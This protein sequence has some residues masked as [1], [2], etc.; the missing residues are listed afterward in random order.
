MAEDAPRVGEGLV[1]GFKG[2]AVPGWL[3]RFESRF[4]L[5]GVILFDYD[6]AAKRHGNNVVSPQQLRGLCAEL[7]ALP[8]RP[9]G[10]AH[11]LPAVVFATVP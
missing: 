1:L 4:G 11:G 8:S 6:P 9:L 3:R 7:S 2:P 10:V 5:G